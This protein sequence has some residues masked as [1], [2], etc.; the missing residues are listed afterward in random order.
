MLVQIEKIK[1]QN[2]IREDNSGLDEL[3]ADI[4]KNGLIN[5]ITVMKTAE[6]AEF[7]YQLLA[8]YRRMM[9]VKSL[10]NGEVEASVLDT[11]T[12]EE[13]LNI[14]ISENEKRK[15][16]TVSEK[17]R[18]GELLEEIERAKARER[19]L[20]GK[21]A[22]PEAILPQ[23]SSG[24]LMEIFPQGTV[25]DIVGDKLG[26]S[27][28]TYEHAK[29]VVEN[30]DPETMAQVDKGET[31]IN[32]AYKETREKQ[33]DPEVTCPQ[34]DNESSDPVEILPQGSD[35]EPTGENAVA[36]PTE[37]T[38]NGV[39]I[40]YKSKVRQHKVGDWI[41]PRERPLAEFP[42]Y[43]AR[44]QYESMVDERHVLC[45]RIDYLERQVGKKQITTEYK[46]FLEK[47]EE[48][49]AK[50]DAESMR[51]NKAE[52]DVNEFILRIDNET[53]DLL[54]VYKAKIEVIKGKNAELEDKV[55]EL[56]YKLFEYERGDEDVGKDDSE[57]D[58]DVSE[59]SR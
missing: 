11:K 1:V 53:N 58:Y 49:K 13:Q 5:P 33:A 59:E 42:F 26:M 22:N 18:F 21:A 19:Q 6:N 2:R 54:A 57:T 27:G 37:L 10:G 41:P 39:K 16:F 34:G 24:D 55:S 51:A 45:Q 20:V 32:A 3:A 31:S 52:K 50:I 30:A 12:A 48:F 23:G 29:Y 43:I 36:E 28:K 44:W 56:Q 8:G 46:G 17:V 25:R 9:A 35:G 4:T 7:E 38:I 15:E 40:P 14:E 47:Y